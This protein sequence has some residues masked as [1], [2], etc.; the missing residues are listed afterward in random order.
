MQSCWSEIVALKKKSY[1]G[2]G[3]FS[4]MSGRESVSKPGKEGL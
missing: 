4:I 3:G 2:G 1:G